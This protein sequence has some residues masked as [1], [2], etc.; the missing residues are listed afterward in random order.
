MDSSSGSMF[1]NPEFSDV[2]IHLYNESGETTI[3]GHMAILAN[4]SKFFEA[5]SRYPRG[6]TI[7]IN[8][9]GI[10]SLEDALKVFEHIYGKCIDNIEYKKELF[11]YFSVEVVPRSICPDIS[12][13]N[14]AF[15][16]DIFD[17]RHKQGMFIGFIY[18][19][20]FSIYFDTETYVLEIVFDAENISLY[21]YDKYLS[22]DNTSGF[23]DISGAII[24]Y[25]IDF[26]NKGEDKLIRWDISQLP[27]GKHHNKSPMDLYNPIRKTNVHYYAEIRETNVHYY[28]KIYD[29]MDLDILKLLFDSKLITLEQFNQAKSQVNELKQIAEELKLEAS[30]RPAIGYVPT[31]IGSQI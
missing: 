4:R 12:E 18:I 5:Y 31:L 20:G 7:D 8:L 17:F 2:T 6:S 30:Q 11:E 29:N 22:K 1:N 14:T 21:A 28:S 25:Y 27:R 23:G 15:V 16:T 3:P 10:G 26:I 24:N 19:K 13:I 9:S